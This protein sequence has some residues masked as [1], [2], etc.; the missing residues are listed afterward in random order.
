MK[1][2]LSPAT[3]RSKLRSG[4]VLAIAAA[5]TLTMSG[6]ATIANGRQQHVVVTSAPSGADVLLNGTSVGTTPATV[7]MRRREPAELEF[8]KAG[9]ATQTVS[10][11]RKVSRWVV[12][13]LIYLNP[14]AA[15][16][17]NSVA[18]W[19][20]WATGWFGAVLA[21]DFVSGG[22]YVRPPVVNVELT[23]LGK[24]PTP[25]HRCQPGCVPVTWTPG[26]ST[27]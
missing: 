12:V 27:P 15:Q 2:P 1:Q 7:R 6:C 9:F 22:A 10:V 5:A 3:S 8:R 19:F 16:G 20:A 18:Q 21:V 14:L 26:I 23:P 4:I 25:P 11:P 17:M 13:N 24:A